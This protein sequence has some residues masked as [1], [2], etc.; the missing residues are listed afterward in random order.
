MGLCKN[1]MSK[2]RGDAVRSS[3]SSSKGNPAPL[4]QYTV[5]HA[6]Y[7]NNPDMRIG[8]CLYFAMPQHCYVHLP[9]RL[10][11]ACRLSP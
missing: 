5:H 10:C 8:Y 7:T 4:I 1:Q 3:I 2:E 9:A 11:G 6:R